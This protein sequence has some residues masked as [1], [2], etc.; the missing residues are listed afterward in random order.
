MK[1][2]TQPFAS[3]L[4]YKAAAMSM[5]FMYGGYAQAQET[6][7]ILSLEQ[8][9]QMAVSVA[10]ELQAAQAK[11]GAQEAQLGSI[12]TWPN[13]TVGMQVDN[14]LDLE[15]GGSGYDLTEISFSQPIPLQRMKH[16]RKQA[17]LGIQKAQAQY[18]QQHLQLEYQV[19]QLFY[20][21]QH[22]SALLK[23]AKQRLYEVQ[24][25]QKKHRS[26]KGEFD[27]LVRYVTPLEVMRLDIV[28][29]TA[30]Q[31][32]AVAEGQYDEAAASFK[33]LLALPLT[34]ALNLPDLTP[35]TL[36][37]SHD[38][39]KA[40]L[41]EHPSL[42]AGTLAVEEAEAGIAVAKANRIGDPVV[43]LFRRTDFLAGQRQAVNGIAVS[44][45]VPFWNTSNSASVEAG[46]VAQQVQADVNT[47]QRDLQ[48]NLHKSYLHYGHLIAQTKHY[49]NKVLK[50]AKKMLNLTHR[51]FDVGELSV[52]TLVDAYNTYFDAQI[53]HTNLLVQAWQELAMLRLSAGLSVVDIASTN[54][55]KTL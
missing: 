22:K 37:L 8:S 20:E 23:L 48:A 31:G 3:L 13:P 17:D 41:R 16:E 25:H 44:V 4:P 26:G 43:T 47:Q 40:A 24:Q 55:E 33:A 9:I 50:P 21:V 1:V 18:Q 46:F 27:P 6:A 30:K 36:T 32:V 38:D 12:N 49:R 34:Q 15:S 2:L 28:L 35:A 7:H 52:L 19:A 53:S 54:V 51:G 45:D 11:L 29:Q 42:R 14:V 5:L 39:L 10:P